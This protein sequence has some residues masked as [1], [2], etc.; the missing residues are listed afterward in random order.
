M[1]KLQQNATALAKLEELNRS[2]FIEN[3]KLN[4]VPLEAD[5]IVHE[6]SA[7]GNGTTNHDTS[8]SYTCCTAYAE[9]LNVP[10]R[11]NDTKNSPVPTSST[12]PP[13]TAGVNRG[14][15]THTV[16]RSA[17][18]TDINMLEHFAQKRGAQPLDG[19]APNHLQVGDREGLVHKKENISRVSTPAS[20]TADASNGPLIQNVI[21]SA[22]STAINMIHIDQK[23]ASESCDSMAPMLLQMKDKRRQV[24]SQE[25]ILRGPPASQSA[26]GNNGSLIHNVLP[27]PK[28]NGINMTGYIVRKSASQSL[29]NSAPKHLQMEDRRRQV[30]SQERVLRERSNMAESTENI[31]TVAGTLVETQ[32][33][34]AKPHADLSTQSKNRRPASPHVFGNE[35]TEASSVHK[36]HVSGVVINSAIIPVQVSSVRGFTVG[37][38]MLG[39]ASLASVNQEEKTVAKEVHDDVTNSCASPKETKQSGMDQHGVQ[40]FKSEA[41]GLNCMEIP[42]PTQPSMNES[43]VSQNLAPVKTSEMERHA[44]KP[45]CKE[46]GLQNLK[47]MLPSD[48]DTSSDNSSTS[49]L[50]SKTPD[51]EALSAPTAI[52]AEIKTEPENWEDGQTSKHRG[53][54]SAASNQVC[55]NS[56]SSA[57]PVMERII[58]CIPPNPR[59]VEYI[60]PIHGPLYMGSHIHQHSPA[61]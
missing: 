58:A 59:R 6:Q 10:L 49:K 21:P 13:G 37:S 43:I 19:S 35:N 51:K 30:L 44:H 16:V 23:G 40:H 5:E 27:S 36:T 29:E 31:I 55:M 60:G 4:D 50:D 53:R 1:G 7:G 9:N 15:L 61:V 22:K 57:A 18:K 42:A 45:A 38:I 11:A 17:K 3:Q 2:L 20:D 24:H 14:S 47:Q 41:G 25:R 28:N 39:D 56:S 34:E 32:N 12:P 48:N 8:T 26:G 33:A 52:K 54:S 46:L